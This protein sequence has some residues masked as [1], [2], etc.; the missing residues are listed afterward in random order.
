MSVPWFFAE[1]LPTVG[2]TWV[3]A[4]DEAKHATSAKR[5]EA[6]DGIV[7]FDGRGHLADA[8]LGG[9]RARDG[10]LQV[11]VHGV[12]EVPRAGRAVQ[13]A[14]ALPK[15]DRLSTLVDMTTQLGV[16]AFMPLRCGRSVASESEHKG[17][18]V[19]RVQIE[20]CKQAHCAWLPTMTPE[21]TPEQLL[22]QRDAKTA[23]VVA[24]P[25]GEPIARAALAQPQ[26]V[27]VCIGPEGGFT[28]AEV[29]QFRAG[30]AVLV[31]LGSTI[32]RIETAAV[33]AVAALR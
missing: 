21:R 29:D 6:G 20:A 14:T 12:R 8:T 15:G 33:V 28:D 11:H 24:H 3:L 18:R 10:S 16:A 19:R 7:L 4:R 26:R 22:K 27:T 5:M 30:G 25:A 9:E 31:D 32:L 17:E 1:T 13:L 23:I 2:G